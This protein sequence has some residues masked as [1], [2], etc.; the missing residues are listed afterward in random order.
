[1]SCWKTRADFK[2]KKIEIIYSHFGKLDRSDTDNI[3]LD[4]ETV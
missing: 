1:M 2:E 3:S 4:Y